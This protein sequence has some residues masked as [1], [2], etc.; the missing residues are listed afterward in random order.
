MLWCA[1]KSVFISQPTHPH[2]N[3]VGFRVLPLPPYHWGAILHL[4]LSMLYDCM[5]LVRTKWCQKF[6]RHRYHEWWLW[7]LL[8]QE[9]EHEPDVNIMAAGSFV[10]VPAQYIYL[11]TNVS[12]HR[13]DINPDH[14]KGFGSKKIH[15]YES[16]GQFL[17]HNKI[18]KGSCSNGQMG[19]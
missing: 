15:V 13:P 16:L 2:L 1:P 17:E 11:E 10:A 7:F 5:I 8:C 12:A 19:F 18:V 3:L 9:T 14:G 6:N 4:G